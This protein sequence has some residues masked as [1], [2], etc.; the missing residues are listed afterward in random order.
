M[1]ITQ[2]GCFPSGTPGQ[3]SL[4]YWWSA[5]R[6]RWTGDKQQRADSLFALVT[7]ELWKDRNGR[8]FCQASST[9]PQILTH[10]KHIAD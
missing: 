1:N 9:V 5:W 2:R 6:A 7:W 3:D 8:C 4:L 10:I